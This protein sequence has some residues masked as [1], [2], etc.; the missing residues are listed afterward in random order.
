MI[1]LVDDVVGDG[2]AVHRAVGTRSDEVVHKAR[3]LLAL[4][5]L[6]HGVQPVAPCDEV[7]RGVDEHGVVGRAGALQLVGRVGGRRGCNSGQRE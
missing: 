4:L 3:V 6:A 1:H 7:V 2:A 5:N